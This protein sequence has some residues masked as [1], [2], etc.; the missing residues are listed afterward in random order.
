MA[1]RKGYEKSPGW[2]AATVVAVNAPKISTMQ[3]AA[4]ASPLAPC[5]VQPPIS[6]PGHRRDCAAGARRAARVLRSVALA[7]I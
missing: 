7:R 2:L 3:T 4:T 1:T 6:Q 5:Q